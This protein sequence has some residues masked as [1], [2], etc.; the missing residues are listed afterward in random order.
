M[1]Y[2]ACCSWV[3]RE[4]TCQIHVFFA[5]CDVDL[6][7][8]AVDYLEIFTSQLNAKPSGYSSCSWNNVLVVTAVQQ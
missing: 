7:I 8:V 4:N 3:G 1:L 5:A 2:T 6:D